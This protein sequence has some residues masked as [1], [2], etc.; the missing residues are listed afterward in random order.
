MA[1]LYCPQQ[2]PG[3]PAP[4][5][6][7]ARDCLVR[8]AAP[9]LLA[10]GQCQVICCPLSPLPS[11]LQI[12]DSPSFLSVPRPRPVRV[13][14]PLRLRRVARNAE[15][16]ERRGGCVLHCAE[17]TC[18]LRQGLS[19]VGAVDSGL[20]LRKWPWGFSNRGLSC[21]PGASQVP[22]RCVASTQGLLH[23]CPEDT[24]FLRV[25]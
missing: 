8:S 14:L 22:T 24:S 18:A 15:M 21:F 9:V 2:Q 13:V 1:C 6:P 4:S 12:I 5:F 16:E 20:A 23:W 25:A 11:V 10:G 17:D 19:W 7:T 3:P